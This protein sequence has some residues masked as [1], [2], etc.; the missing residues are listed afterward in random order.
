MNFLY[1]LILLW[2][3]GYCHAICEDS[4]WKKNP[5]TKKKKHGKNTT[6][7]NKKKYNGHL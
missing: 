1:L 3:H 4:K 5:K 2:N 6:N 7:K